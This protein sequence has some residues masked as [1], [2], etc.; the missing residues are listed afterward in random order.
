MV[1]FF[2]LSLF[3]SSF[4]SFL[5]DRCY[6]SSASVRCSFLV[7]FLP[8]SSFFSLVASSALCS[9]RLS[10]LGGLYTSG[11][12]AFYPPPAFRVALLFPYVLFFLLF[13]DVASRVINP[14]FV[15]FPRFAFSRPG[16]SHSITLFSYVAP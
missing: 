7:F 12:R 2:S 14:R 5:E 13:I 11:A 10:L 6:A 8:R 4:I 16:G 3:C 15:P 1:L 9:A